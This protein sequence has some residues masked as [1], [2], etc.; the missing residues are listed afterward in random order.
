MEKY[1]QFRDRGS[2]FKKAFLWSMLGVSGVWWIDLQIDGVK[3]GSLAK[4][5]AHRL[6]QPSDIIASSL[7][8][9]IDALYLA[10]IFNP[11]FTASYPHTRLVRRVSLLGAIL[12]AFQIPQEHP[13]NDTE[14]V[15]VRSI[16]SSHPNRIVVVFPE[17]TTTNGRGILPFSPSIL[18]AATGSKIF[19]ISLRYSPGDITTPV[20]GTYWS[21]LWNFLSEPTHCIRVRIAGCVFN[22]SKPLHSP[23]SSDASNFLDTS[24]AEDSATTSS[25][26]TLSTFERQAGDGQTLEERKVLERTAEAL[27]RLGRSKR[28]GLTLKDKIAF[29][30]AWSRQRHRR[31]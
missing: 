10:A 18:S 28:I 15:H 11:I 25:T 16:T 20:P 22:A 8:S 13:T 1:S 17:C 9:P 23:T 6:P 24:P 14:L 2:L 4:Q 31:R 19:P 7:T 5:H 26:E 21:F 12:R 30:D 27:A 29:I 3:R